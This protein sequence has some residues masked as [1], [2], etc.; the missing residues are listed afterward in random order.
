M[1]SDFVFGVIQM[2]DGEKD[3]RNLLVAFQLFVNT[4]KNLP[5]YT[6]F[7]EELF[8]I[9]SCY[10]PITFKPRPDDPDSI[11]YE[12]L[13]A[14]LRACFCAT[15][16]FAPFC[17]SFLLDKLTSSVYATKLETLITISHCSRAFGAAAIRPYLNQLWA[18]VRDEVSACW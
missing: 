6:R 12:E 11:T 13:S 1:K 7:T 4:I 17:F 14:A 8:E 10:F 5:D 2:I 18:G 16:A 3:P 15:A 9:V